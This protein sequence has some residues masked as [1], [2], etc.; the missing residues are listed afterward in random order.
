MKWFIVRRGPHTSSISEQI[1]VFIVDLKQQQRRRWWWWWWWWWCSLRGWGQ[2]WG[3]GVRKS[4]VRR[5]SSR[6]TE[7]RPASPGPCSQ[8]PAARC[9]RW[10]GTRYPAGPEAARLGEERDRS[11]L[12][13]WLTI[14]TEFTF[15]LRCAAELHLHYNTSAHKTHTTTQ[16][17]SSYTKFRWYTMKAFLLVPPCTW[18]LWHKNVVRRIN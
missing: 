18:L 8:S 12:T 1:Q 11:P 3:Q 4:K 6:R 14:T 9:C 2:C 17:T 16:G 10:R 13:V 7:D 5:T 15:D